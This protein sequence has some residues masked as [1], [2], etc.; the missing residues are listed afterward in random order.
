LVRGRNLGHVLKD[1]APNAGNSHGD[2]NVEG[3]KF[4]QELHDL[5]KVT[6]GV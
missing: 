2:G 1:L 5:N 4:L 6:Q 3:D